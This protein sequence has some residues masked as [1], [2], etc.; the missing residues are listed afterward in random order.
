[1][2]KFITDPDTVD[3]VTQ[4]IKD[5]YV[6]QNLPIGRG[7]TTEFRK[8]F[9]TLL[10]GEEWKIQRIV[11]TTVNKMRNTA[12]VMYMSDAG[13]EKYAVMG[14][15]D[16]LQCAWCKSLQGKEFTVA[17]SKANILHLA[18]SDPDSVDSVAPFIVGKVSPDEIS[19]KTGEELQALGYDLPPFHCN[20]RDTIVAV[21]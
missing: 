12:G 7:D 19:T 14:I 17:V 8:D 6:G 13:V 2:G 1:L 10:K 5:R 11:S 15:N 18:T 9:A 20:C 16:R 4:F 21:L 3:R